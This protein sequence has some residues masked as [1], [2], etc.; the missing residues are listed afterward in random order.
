MRYILRNKVFFVTVAV[1]LAFI[2]TVFLSCSNSSSAKPNFIFK[3]A[4]RSD[5]V[6]KI[7]NEEI[8]EERLIGDNKIAFFDLKN[9][10]TN[11]KWIASMS[12]SLRF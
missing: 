12:F 4:P 8:T 11:L 10:N 7:G 9:K 6:A 1:A 3:N 2:S 5:L